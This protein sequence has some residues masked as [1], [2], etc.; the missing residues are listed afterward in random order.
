MKSKEKKYTIIILVTLVVLCSLWLLPKGLPYSHDIEYHYTRL[1]GLTETIKN[2]DFIALIHDML[3]GYGYANGLFYSNFFF[4]I[5]ALFNLIGLSAVDSYKLFTI[6]INIATVL[7]SYFCFKRIIKDRRVVLFSTIVYT[8]S[9]YR[10]MGL[11]VRGACGEL[12]ALIFIP[13]ILLGLYEIIYRDYKKWY[14]F[15]IGFIFLLLSHL[16]SSVLMGLFSVIIILINYK[17]FIKEKER[18]KYL[19]LSGLV[20]VLVDSFFLFPLIEQFIHKTVNIFAVGSSKTMPYDYAVSLFEFFLPIPYS[21]DTIH[22]KNIGYGILALLIIPF[23]YR[24]EKTKKSDESSYAKILLIISLILIL[25]TTNLFPWKQLSNELSFIQFPWRLLFYSSSFLPLAL[26]IYLDFLFTKKNIKE[27]SILK[28]F[29]MCG[30]GILVLCTLA[31][32]AVYAV[33]MPRKDSF[34]KKIGLGEYLPAGVD[35][36]SEFIGEPCEGDLEL[37]EYYDTNNTS[38]EYEVT[39]KGKDIHINYKN[40]NMKDTYLEIP[41]F[42]YLGYKVDGAKLSDGNYHRIKLLLNNNESG[43][44]HIYYAMTKV[45]KASYVISFVSIIGITGT[46][47]ILKKKKNK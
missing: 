38:L 5:P 33:I 2:G 37:D 22:L 21:Q 43:E 10:I 12:L 42:N 6:L 44:I 47:I 14:L 7:S 8:I 26:G 39:R 4:Y 40:N 11:I 41:V 15:S 36:N 13:I 25:I 20:G 32:N 34:R 45:Q 24:K 27:K 46:I 30:I 31:Y 35:I 16:I 18:I 3:S 1:L 19:L 17:R 23:V 9:T 28:A 29:V